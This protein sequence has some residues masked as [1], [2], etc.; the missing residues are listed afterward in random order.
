MLMYVLPKELEPH[1]E[2]AARASGQ[3]ERGGTMHYTPSRIAAALGE[4]KEK[5]IIYFKLA[6]EVREGWYFHYIDRTSVRAYDQ[7]GNY[8]YFEIFDLQWIVL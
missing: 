3:F 4:L 6:D 5:H 7:F 2:A 8:V 1:E